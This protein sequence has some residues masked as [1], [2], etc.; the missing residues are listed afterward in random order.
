ML[1]CHRA[2]RMLASSIFPALIVRFVTQTLEQVGHDVVA[3]RVCSNQTKHCCVC[4]S[5]QAE[6]DRQ[7][8][9]AQGTDDAEQ[10]RF[11]RSSSGVWRFCADERLRNDVTQR[12]NAPFVLRCFF[13]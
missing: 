10:S 5:K 6:T 11:V 13:C 3:V 8:G 2:I 4:N 7:H 1:S 9:A 12:R